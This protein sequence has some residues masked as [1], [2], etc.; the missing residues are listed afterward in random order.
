VL[1]NLRCS[2]RI[3]T[4]FALDVR[5]RCLFEQTVL[6]GAKL[7]KVHG[8]VHELRDAWK[9]AVC[10]HISARSVSAVGLDSGTLRDLPTDLNKVRDDIGMLLRP[11]LRRNDRCDAET[12]YAVRFTKDHGRLLARDVL[13]HF[14]TGDGRGRFV[15]EVLGVG[16]NR[17][18]G[19]RTTF[20]FN[21]CRKVVFGDWRKEVA[22]LQEADV[23]ASLIPRD[24][25][26]HFRDLICSKFCPIEPVP[27]VVYGEWVGTAA[28]ETRYAPQQRVDDV[29]RYRS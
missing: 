21:E 23:R 19:P 9:L 18:N 17:S 2:S 28:I 4:C 25:G 26:I 1:S 24:D 15:L 10:D 5:V 6:F 7:A 16:T 12:V 11:A 27:D 3:Q 20:P 13:H 29:L 22:V 8:R 14:V